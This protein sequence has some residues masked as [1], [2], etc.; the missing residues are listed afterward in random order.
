MAMSRHVKLLDKYDAEVIEERYNPL[1]ERYEI[2][3]KVV[4]LG[5][6]TPSR[7]VIKLGVSK[8][9]GKDPSLV[10]IRKIEPRYGFPESIIEVH[11]YNSVERAKLFEPEHIVKRDEE[12]MSK[13]T[14]QQ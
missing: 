7:G 6:G 2:K 1:I 3:M 4:H 10:Y 12:S 5:E 11:V 14:T 13:T 8:L 9:Y